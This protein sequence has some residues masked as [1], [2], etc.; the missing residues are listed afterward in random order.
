MTEAENGTVPHPA[1]DAASWV[2]EA[3]AKI[4]LFLH[5]TG[6]RADGYH[7][8]QSLFVYLDLADRLVAEP[9]A[10][11]SCDRLAVTGPMAGALVEEAAADNLV[12]QALALLRQAGADLP[13]LAI[14]LD[15]RIPVAAGLGGGSADAAAALRLGQRVLA[16]RHAPPLPGESMAELALALGA[17]VPPA[18]ASRPSWVEGIGERLAPLACPSAWA[19]LRVLLVNPNRPLATGSVFRRWA[20]EGR[21]FHRPIPRPSDSM[22]RSAADV[23]SWLRTETTNDLEPAAQAL[24]PAVCAVLEA[25]RE[26]PGC[27]LARMSGSGATC[28]GLFF[29]AQ[30]AERAC[31]H[32]RQGHPEWWTALARIRQSWQGD[33]AVGV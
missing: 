6:R 33:A 25:L 24:E 9:A 29:D 7:L 31:L 13:P 15:K 21:A 20:Q 32:L 11:A 16:T 1:A 18:L 26:R 17:D 4:N 5:V 30:A 3:P 2:E 23:V 14:T 19:D 27:L 12:L 28:F 22:F 8:L 10:P